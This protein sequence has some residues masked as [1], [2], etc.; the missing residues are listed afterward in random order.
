MRNFEDEGSRIK[1]LRTVADFMRAA[2]EVGFYHDDCSS[3]HIMVNAKAWESKQSSITNALTSGIFTFI[4]VDN[5]KLSARP[6]AHKYRVYNIFQ[7]IRS[8]DGRERLN[9]REKQ[10]FIEAYFRELSDGERA[11]IMNRINQIA[12]RKVGKSIV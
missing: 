4:D 3:E 12:K 1:A 9:D 11:D 5:A 7:I 10:E 8:M 6:I 2:Y